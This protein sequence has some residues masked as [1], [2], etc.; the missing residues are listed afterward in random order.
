MLE[1]VI[2][3][4][5]IVLL[6]ATGLG[7][8]LA[9]RSRARFRG[10]NRIY[11]K[12]YRA[13]VVKIIDTGG[14][15]HLRPGTVSL[16]LHPAGAISIDTRIFTWAQVQELNILEN[17]PNGRCLAVKIE[18]VQSEWQVIFSARRGIDGLAGELQ[19][20]WRRYYLN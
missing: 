7:F 20:A 4:A 13:A 9:A 16:C 14:H 1:S 2:W 17:G 12:P 18:D 3:S 11:G 6:I 19:Q 8:G 5:G 15:P 10:I